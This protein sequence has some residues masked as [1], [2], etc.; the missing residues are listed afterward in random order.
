MQ[1]IAGKFF[2][3]F[4]WRVRGSGNRHLFLGCNIH[5]HNLDVGADAVKFK[6][7]F[8]RCHQNLEINQIIGWC[9]ARSPETFQ[10]THAFVEQSQFFFVQ[11]NRRLQIG[12]MLGKDFRHLVF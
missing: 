3:I 12:H 10:Q 8:P 9:T 1:F 5:C 4:L 6:N 7:D 2:Q 11:L